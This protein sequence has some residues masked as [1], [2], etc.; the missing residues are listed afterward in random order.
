MVLIKKTID[1]ICS[2]F[3]KTSIV[4]LFLVIHDEENENKL[5]N[6]KY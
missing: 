4:F 1:V 5:P 6:M 3:T 2:D